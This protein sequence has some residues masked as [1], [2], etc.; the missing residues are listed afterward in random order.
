MPIESTSKL[1]NYI[2]ASTSSFNNNSPNLS[3]RSNKRLFNG[4]RGK[5]YDYFTEASSASDIGGDIIS[6][7]CNSTLI[8]EDDFTDA[9][10][11]KSTL[12]VIKKRAKKRNIENEGNEIVI[13]EKK[14]FASGAVIGKRRRMKNKFGKE[15]YFLLINF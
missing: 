9:G 1:N 10:S 3:C 15:L 12:F 4:I 13:N 2:N 8:D 14:S 11:P 7:S 5:G 6:E